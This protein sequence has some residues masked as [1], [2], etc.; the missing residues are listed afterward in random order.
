M[1]LLINSNHFPYKLHILTFIRIINLIM[2][3]FNGNII[4][5]SRKEVFSKFLNEY[6]IIQYMFN[7]IST[8]LISWS[9]SVSCTYAY[10]IDFFNSVI[11]S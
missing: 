10:F 5:P 3:L 6:N 11:C 7:K 1:L 8:D 4:L 9:M 2:L